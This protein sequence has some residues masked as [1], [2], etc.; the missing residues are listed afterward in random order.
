MPTRQPTFEVQEIYL[1]Q[2]RQVAK[3]EEKEDAQFFGDEWPMMNDTAQSDGWRQCV[4]ALIERVC[5]GRYNRLEYFL[6]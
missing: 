5:H 3:K 6:F 1:T 2:R 4:C